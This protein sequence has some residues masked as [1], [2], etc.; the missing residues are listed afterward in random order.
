M[1]HSQESACLTKFFIDCG[2]ILNIGTAYS[3]HS[4]RIRKLQ[5]HSVDL[6]TSSA[7]SWHLTTRA[8]A[9]VSQNSELIKLLAC[10]WKL[11]NPHHNLFMKRWRCWRTAKKQHGGEEDVTVEGL[12]STERSD[13]N[14]ISLNVIWWVVSGMWNPDK[15]QHS[16]PDENILKS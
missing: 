3:D 7:F 5:N 4:K 1:S 9:S 11:A 8:L 10:K 14:V 12:G 16:A 6:L 15:N 2:H 13:F